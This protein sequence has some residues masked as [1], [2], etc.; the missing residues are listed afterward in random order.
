MP[1]VPVSFRGSQHSHPEKE[2]V[3]QR[4]LGENKCGRESARGTPQPSPSQRPWRP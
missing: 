2:G 1:F 3:D 4:V